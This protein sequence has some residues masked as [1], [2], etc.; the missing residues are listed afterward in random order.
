MTVASTFSKLVSVVSGSSGIVTCSTTLPAKINDA[1]LPVAIV[2]PG[3]A[4]WN[5]QAQGL[6][7]QV[8]TYIVKVFVKPTA[9]GLG[10]DEGVQACYAPLNA[11]G[12][13][14]LGNLSL[15]N[16]IDH[17]SEP[18][19]DS[20]IISGGEAMSYAGVAYHGFEYHIDVVDKTT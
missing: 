5:E 2:I 1:D 7:R 10:I 8:R 12:N 17:I 15:D 6:K 18:F 4:E 19:R 13:T 20:G 9:Q 3:P 16:T 11:L 14:I